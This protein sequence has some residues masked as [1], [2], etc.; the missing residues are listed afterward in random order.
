MP[1]RNQH[2]MTLDVARKLLKRSPQD[3]VSLQHKFGQTHGIRV[4]MQHIPNS[5][6]VNLLNV[7]DAASW[8]S[9]LFPSGLPAISGVMPQIDRLF[10]RGE[11]VPDVYD[12]G[13]V[14]FAVAETKE[15]RSERYAG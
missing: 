11:D 10:S 14:H 12:A 13:L 5:S 3:F 4:D 8:I 9:R 1:N 7:R 2:A 6:G 15:P